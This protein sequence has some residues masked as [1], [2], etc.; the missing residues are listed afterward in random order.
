MKG[1]DMTRAVVATAVKTIHKQII[2]ELHPDVQELV[3]EYDYMVEDAVE[4]I[5]LCGSLDKAM[6]YLTKKESEGGFEGH[7]LH[8]T[9][10]PDI[11]ER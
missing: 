2:D 3:N 9:W 6:D 4:S 11:E 5:Q 10:E 1:A 8:S 7:W